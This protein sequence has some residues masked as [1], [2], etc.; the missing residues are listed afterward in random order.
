MEALPEYRGLFQDLVDGP[1]GIGCPAIASVAGSTLILVVTEPTVSGRHDLERILAL[2]RHFDIPTAV[3]VNKW[4]LNP[5]MTDRIEDQARRARARIVS[6]I[7]YDPW[8]TRAQMQGRAVVKTEAP[9]A[10]D[11]RDIWNRLS[12]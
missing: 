8:V 5:E 3:C 7:R 6:R 1:P 12:L 4:D 11:I 9:S 2:T 10:D